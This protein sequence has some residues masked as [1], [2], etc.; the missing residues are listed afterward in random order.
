[1]LYCI[2][3]EAGEREWRYGVAEGLEGR[4]IPAVSLQAPGEQV[5]LLNCANPPDSETSK[6]VC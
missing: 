3:F 4:L 5:I 2:V 6:L 1:M